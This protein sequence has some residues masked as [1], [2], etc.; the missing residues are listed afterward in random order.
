MNDGRIS[1]TRRRPGRATEASAQEPPREAPPRRRDVFA[2]PL[3][4]LRDTLRA[5][6]RRPPSNQDTARQP[7]NSISGSLE[8]NAAASGGINLTNDAAEPLRDAIPLRTGEATNTEALLHPATITQTTEQLAQLG[9]DRLRNIAPLSLTPPLNPPQLRVDPSLVSSGR[10]LSEIPI[11]PHMEDARATLRVPDTGL[12]LPATEPNRTA[13]QQKMDSLPIHPHTAVQSVAANGQY[14]IKRTRGLMNAGQQAVRSAAESLESAHQE[15]EAS[16]LRSA[17]RTESLHESMQRAV[18]ALQETSQSIEQTT[19]AMPTSHELPPIRATVAS[20]HNVSNVAQNLRM[21]EAAEGLRATA[22]LVQAV[23]QENPNLRLTHP[24]ETILASLNGVEKLA[25]IVGRVSRS[26]SITSYQ[27]A[28]L[29]ARAGSLNPFTS[30]AAQSPVQA[31]DHA[32]HIP[33]FNP[34]PAHRQ[35]IAPVLQAAMVQA[36]QPAEASEQEDAIEPAPPRS[37]PQR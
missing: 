20:L 21:R 16:L 25:D 22:Q 11:G 34:D 23:A 12:P 29:S 7:S 14:L 27:A 36:Q 6:G 17:R 31:S 24:V 4:S 33:M 9:L 28:R 2:S 10:P 35:A 13:I 30:P 26:I 1:T 18:Q 8:A 5:S 15:M 37:E 3:R 19:T 32:A